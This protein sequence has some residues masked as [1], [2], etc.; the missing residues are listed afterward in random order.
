L[1]E[2]VKY[3]SDG[4]VCSHRRHYTVYTHFTGRGRQGRERTS[5]TGGLHC[6]LFEKAEPSQE[7]PL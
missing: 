2:H 5:H 1:N 7:L 3:P 4:V 6:F